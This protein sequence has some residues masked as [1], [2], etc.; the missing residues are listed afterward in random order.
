MAMVA[1]DGI[2]AEIH[3]KPLLQFEHAILDPLSTVLVAMAGIVIDTA[4]EGASDATRDAVVVGCGFQA[5]L[6]FSG[7][8][9]DSI[10]ESMRSIDVLYVRTI[11]SC[12]Q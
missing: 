8:R 6:G 1:H 4:E 5:N 3:G 7:C 2:R 9:H 11:E 12:C 10:L